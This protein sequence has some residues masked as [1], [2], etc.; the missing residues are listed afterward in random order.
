MSQE[1]RV[2]SQELRNSIITILEFYK[3]LGFRKL[4]LDYTN[5][6]KVAGSKIKEKGLPDS[7]LSKDVALNA[8]IDEIGNCQK[9]RLSTARTNIVFGEGNPD[10]DIMFIGEAP[11]VE[12]DLQARPFIGEAGQLLTSLI[13]RMGFKREDVYIANIIK[14]RPPMNRDP[15]EDEV[16]AC[17]PF[18]DRQIQ[19]ISPEIIISL[20]K[21]S[22]HSLLNISVPISKF[23]ITKIRGRFR[24][25]KGITVMPTFH[26]AYLMRNPR[27]KWLTWVDAIV[28][29][30]KIGLDDRAI[31][32][33]SET[34]SDLR[35]RGK[36][37]IAEHLKIEI[38]RGGR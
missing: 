7:S 37:E 32:L 31:R 29:L 25:Y 35:R 5:E 22:A 33:E 12:E 24:T 20:G 17:F 8:L 38:R 36:F 4:P 13:E 26:P 18:L 9:C 19:I 1:S 27:D 14:C 30:K 15:R 28:T 10:A 3:E 16:A 2:K 6:L 23:S 21:I 11:G 34:I